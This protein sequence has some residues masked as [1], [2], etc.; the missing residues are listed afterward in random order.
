MSGR[1]DSVQGLLEHLTER[2]D[3][4]GPLRRSR[5]EQ[6][7]CRCGSS[8]SRWMRPFSIFS[9]ARNTPCAS[10]TSVP[11]TLLTRSRLLRRGRHEDLSRWTRRLGVRKVL[12]LEPQPPLVLEAEP[13]DRALAAMGN[14]ADLVSPYLAGHSSGVAELGCCGRKRLRDRRGGIDGDPA[15][16]PPS[17]PRPGGRP[18]AHLAEA[19]STDRRR[20]G[21]GAPAPL[22]EARSSR[23]PFL[24]GLSSIAGAHHERLDGS[25]YH[26]GANG[27]MSSPL[28]PG[29]SP[30]PTPTMR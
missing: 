3:G 5:G 27:P 11:G 1:P 19:R 2:W 7:R 6:I 8:T 15:G 14:F 4:K 20:V 28:R 22:R 26:R 12:A 23:S 21:A 10:C 17:R 16:G 13:L 18:S 30:R 29:C 25:G 24:S 9:A